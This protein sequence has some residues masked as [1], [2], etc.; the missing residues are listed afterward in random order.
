MTHEYSLLVFTLHRRKNSKWHKVGSEPEELL[1]CMTDLYWIGV[2]RDVLEIIRTL[3]SW[4]H[5]SYNSIAVDD[6]ESEHAKNRSGNL[7]GFGTFM[8]RATGNRAI[9]M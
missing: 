9:D 7:T 8:H 5:E 3:R 4:R 1:G 6:A 2:H